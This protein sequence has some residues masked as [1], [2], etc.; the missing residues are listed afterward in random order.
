MDQRATVP[1][2]LSDHFHGHID[3]RY[4]H[5]TDIDDCCSQAEDSD[6]SVLRT[7]TAAVL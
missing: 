3:H 4:N 6:R 1:D 2:R 5:H 7:I